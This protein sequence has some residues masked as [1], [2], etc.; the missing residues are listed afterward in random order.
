ATQTA[1]TTT[2]ASG[3]TKGGNA[4]IGLSLALVVA[5]HDVEA[6]LNR[7]L[8]APGD[9]SST[10]YKGVTFQADGVS[11]NDTKAEASSAG[12]KDSD[13]DTSG[14][15]VNKKSDDNLTAASTGNDKSG[16]TSSTK[17]PDAKSG[18][19]GGTKVTVAAAV[20]IG[21][22]TA[23][24]V[25]KIADAIHVVTTGGAAGTGLLKLSSSEDTDSTVKASGKASKAATANIG[26]A[27]ALKLGHVR[28]AA[29][30]G[31]DDPLTV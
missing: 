30:A 6:L 5:N 17:T 1:K 27:G 22:V 4:G 21:I 12:A 23:T 3:D 7:D 31:P 13:S 16:K 15:D 14:K 29:G 20:A 8:I 25:A 10:D 2:K 28:K 18:E 24:A 11:T 26:A 19:N 9:A